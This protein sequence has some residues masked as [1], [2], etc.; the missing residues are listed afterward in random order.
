MPLTYS[1]NS[2][3]I[4]A[5]GIKLDRTYHNILDYSESQMLTLINSSANKV[6]ET[7]NASFFRDSGYLELEV[8]YG[9]AITA[10]YV[11]FQNPDYSDKWFFAFIDKVEYRSDKVTRIHYTVDEL[12]TW[13]DYWTAKSCF[14]V[15]EHVNDDTIGANTVPEN[16]E[17]GEYAILDIRNIPMYEGGDSHPD[18]LICFCVTNLP[19][20][21]SSIVDEAQTVGGVF[22][23]MHFFAVT[24]MGAARQVITVYEEREEISTDA[25]KN[26]FMIPRNCVDINFTNGQTGQGHNPTVF[27][28]TSVG[29]GVSVYPL[30]DSAASGPYY[31]QQPAVLAGNYTPK[32]NKLYTWPFSGAY[33][34]NKVGEDVVVHWED[35]PIQT[36]GS[37]TSANTA[38]TIGYKVAFV[39]CASVS[40]KLYFTNYKMKAEGTG[41]GERLYNYSINYPKIPVCA[42]TTDYYTNW[43]TQ[44]GVNVGI[45]VASGFA[46]MVGGAFGLGLGIATGGALLPA[47]AALAAGGMSITNS[48]LKVRDAA[49]TPDQA[50]GDINVGDFSYC[51]TRCSISLYYMTV[52]PEYAAQIDDYFDRLGYKI[53]RV[54]VPNQTGRTYWNYVQIAE[55][56]NIGYSGSTISV[57]AGSMD[58]INQV[59]RSGVTIWHSHDNLGNYSL[60]NSIVTP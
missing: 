23:A 48:L 3:A 36:I 13:H 42:W 2:R 9:T 45:N 31:F 12:S 25:I 59:Y 43:L 53:N 14:V 39:P 44:N 7:L 18:W 49:I 17:T 55:S 60:T 15:R 11:G 33:F 38:R 29:G 28:S 41:Y 5:K 4:L 6:Y 16:I 30:L 40:G 51:F 46:G 47:A 1:R 21:A 32:N 27:H 20:N 34:T 8:P 35:F 52:R 54:K 22:S 58:V 26:V 24:T 56:E 50:K 37:G 57:P 10:N 19:E